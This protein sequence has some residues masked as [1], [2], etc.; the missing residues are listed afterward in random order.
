[1]EGMVDYSAPGSRSLAEI[2]AEMR[3]QSQKTRQKQEQEQQEQRRMLEQEA[4][5]QA[6]IHQQQR[7]QEQQAAQHLQ[8]MHLQQQQA[9]PPR[10]RSDSPSIYHTSSPMPS[11]QSAYPFS[12]DSQRQQQLLLREVENM[13]IQEQQ[14]SLRQ[15]LA[16]LPP[17][18]RAQIPAYVDPIEFMVQKTAQRE[19]NVPLGLGQVRPPS[20]R[21]Q[22]YDDLA[23]AQM[24]DQDRRVRGQGDDL[25]R[26]QI[27]ID[28]QRQAQLA[29]AGLLDPRR[30][31]PMDQMQAQ[32][33]VAMANEMTNK[34][35]GDPAGN[36]LGATPADI[37]QLQMQQRMLAQL[38]QQEFAK[39]MGTNGVNGQ[40][41]IPDLKQQ[42][43][44]RAEVMRKIMETEQ[45]E[46]RRRRKAAKISH[47][48]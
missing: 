19:R 2:E 4:Q 35:R 20:T 3:A 15:E 36:I 21:Q 17:E 40:N 8:Q 48:V 28:Q 11:S 18:V 6:M 38:A 10:M 14:H 1:M 26:R 23:E 33:R 30:Q 22:R 24:K 12:S 47:M 5:L 9:K 45:Q 42:E 32:L 44:L 41:T 37:A 7:L 13:R 43:A 46:A 31:S 27:I 39:S 29:A 25:I 16:Q 34:T